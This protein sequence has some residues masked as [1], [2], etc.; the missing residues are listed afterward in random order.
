MIPF[1][2]HH[3]VEV[4]HL[5]DIASAFQAKVVFPKVRARQQVGI[6]P[7][8]VFLV[9]RAVVAHQHVADAEYRIDFLSQ[10]FIAAVNG[11]FCRSVFLHH[12]LRRERPHR[13]TQPLGANP[14]GIIYAAAS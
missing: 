13:R 10:E 7:A 3:F 5:N 6:Y 2:G 8:G 11:I 4:V 1:V 12:F 9:I 14:H